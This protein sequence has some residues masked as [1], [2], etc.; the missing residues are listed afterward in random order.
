MLRPNQ[1]QR[2]EDLT[3]SCEYQSI[4]PKKKNNSGVGL[5][6]WAQEQI[7]NLPIENYQQAEESKQPSN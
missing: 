1:S 5:T 7:I 4:S 3:S 2:K 6:E